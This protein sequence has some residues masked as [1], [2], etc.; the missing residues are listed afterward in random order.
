M[1]ESM[2]S[3]DLEFGTGLGGLVAYNL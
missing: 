3:A 1:K 2:G